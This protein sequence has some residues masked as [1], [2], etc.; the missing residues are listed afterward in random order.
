[1]SNKDLPTK[2]LY[3]VGCMYMFIPILQNSYVMQG[4]DML[5]SSTWCQV[6][7]GCT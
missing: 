4:I 6:D 5:E 7:T 1:M 2:Q 3:E